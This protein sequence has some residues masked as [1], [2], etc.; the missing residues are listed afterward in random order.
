MATSGD[1]LSFGDFHADLRSGELFRRGKKLPLQEK[2]FR[3]LA[4]L[5]RNAGRVVSREELIQEFWPGPFAADD[6]LN[7]AIRKIRQVLRDDPKRPKYLET[8]AHGYRFVGTMRV[9][10]PGSGSQSPAWIGLLRFNQISESGTN[11]FADGLAEE[12]VS[13][14]G[15]LRPHGLAVTLLRYKDLAAAG[16]VCRRL[17]LTWVLTGTVRTQGHRVRLSVMLQRVG[18]GEI[19]WAETFERDSDDV[20]RVQEW[21]AAS[22]TNGL[23]E[24]LGIGHPAEQTQSAARQLYQK[25]RFF[26]NKR[27]AAGLH[28]AAETFRKCIELDPSFALAYAGLADVAVMEAKHGIVFPNEAYVEAKQLA[29]KALELDKSLAEAYVPLAWADLVY[30]R[31]WDGAEQHFKRAIELNPNYATGHSGYAFLLTAAARF[32]EAERAFQKALELD[33]LSLPI[34]TLFGSMLNYKGDCQ[35]AIRQ[36]QST[37]ELDSYFALARTS[38]ALAYAGTGQWQAAIMHS[39]AAAEIGDVNPLVLGAIGYVYAS[40]GLT[41]EAQDVLRQ[42]RAMNAQTWV[43][44][45][46]ALVHIALGSHEAALD[47]LEAGERVASQWILFCAVNPRVAPL[48]QHSRFRAL[49]DVLKLKPY[50]TRESQP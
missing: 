11:S 10:T 24:A 19:H 21:L 3:V 29:L 31:D 36:L 38:L 28:T 25:A 1:S 43:P 35:G 33:P 16:A 15:R 45:A 23:A 17:G 6:G 50:V 18:K 30:S 5:L 41:A 20:F 40:A 42:L 47:Y 26:W 2:P 34:N 13:G 22:V 9:P 8:V 12:I 37:L 7:T 49:L 32:D 44:E 48:H 4:L 14:L 46:L 39:R 27:T